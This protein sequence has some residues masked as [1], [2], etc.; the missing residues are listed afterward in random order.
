[1]QP[2]LLNLIH[3]NSLLKWFETELFNL[4]IKNPL[5][6]LFLVF[7]IAM[8]SISRINFRLIY[9][10]FASF[11]TNL[12]VREIFI[13]PTNL[14]NPYIYAL[15]KISTIK[16]TDDLILSTCLLSCLLIK[17]R[18]SKWIWVFC[19]NYL[20]GVCLGVIYFKIK[21][22]I[23]IPLSIVIICLT[24]AISFLFSSRVDRGLLKIPPILCLIASQLLPITL[25]YVKHVFPFSQL[26]A[27]ASGMGFG[28]Y[29]SLYRK[30]FFMQTKSQ[31][32]SMLKSIFAIS[33]TFSIPLLTHY[34]NLTSVNA[35][36]FLN[37]FFIGFWLGL[38]PQ[39]LY[40]KTIINDMARLSTN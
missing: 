26:S 5:N 40:S 14:A 3:V 6:W 15:K 2:F 39:I 33:A 32:E 9:L 30:F 10:I 27:V 37:F 36:D 21:F 24:A 29:A 17:L 23:H 8:I 34:F 18:T 38:G 7:L 1:M 13:I 11:I 4:G 12:A 25:L 22:P 31:Y 16:F 35:D 19:M 20:I 28:I